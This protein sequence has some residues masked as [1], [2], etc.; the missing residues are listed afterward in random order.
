MHRPTRFVYRLGTLG[1]F[2]LRLPE[3]LCAA[4]QAA[5]SASVFAGRVLS[6]GKS[7]LFCNAA[8]FCVCVW[9]CDVLIRRRLALLP[10]D[11]LKMLIFVQLDFDPV[12]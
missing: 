5:A 12:W 8:Y 3:R 10:S 6:Q 4:R 9:R 1:L 7:F 11:H 2:S